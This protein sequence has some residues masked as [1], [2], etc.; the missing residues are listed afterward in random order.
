MWCSVAMSSFVLPS[1]VVGAASG[2]CSGI[3]SG[4]ELCPP[5][6]SEI[7][8]DF[9]PPLADHAR[10]TPS[11]LAH[12]GSAVLAAP[13][14]VLGRDSD[15]VPGCYPE[16]LAVAASGWVYSRGVRAIMC[17]AWLQYSGFVCLFLLTPEVTGAAGGAHSQAPSGGRP[18]LPL[19]SKTTSTVRPCCL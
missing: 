8:G 18:C 19:V 6:E 17:D 11:H 15:Q 5:L 3:P 1:E 2:S 9:P 10:S 12:A 14:R 16:C 7:T 13:S 4:G